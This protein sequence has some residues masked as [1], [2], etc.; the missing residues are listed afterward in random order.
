MSMSKIVLFAAALLLAQAQAQ[1][2]FDQQI[3]ECQK[4]VAAAKQ[5]AVQKINQQ[6]DAIKQAEESRHSAALQQE[7]SSY[8][9]QMED[10]ED[11]YQK[12]IEEDKRIAEQ[13]KQTL[14]TQHSDTIDEEAQRFQDRLATVDEEKDQALSSLE[15]NP[16][17]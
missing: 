7:D 6:G 10:T 17:K 1:T 14:E 3:S 9:E 4:A 2:S 12:K 5:E 11:E 8:E 15:G 13:K 16:K